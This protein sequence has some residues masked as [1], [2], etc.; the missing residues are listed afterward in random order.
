MIRHIRSKLA[1]GLAMLVCLPVTG[2]AQ[3]KHIRV[4]AASDLQVVMPQIAKAFEQQARIGVELTYGSSG[5]FFAQI[6]N[7][8]PFDLFFSADSEFPARL[9]RGGAAD[10]RSA[11]V[12][13]LGGL[14][15]WV[16]A[17]AKCNPQAERW[18]CLLKADVSKIAIANPAHAPY[19]RAAISAIQ[20]AGVYEQVRQKLVFGENISQA[21][22]F[23]QSGNAQAGVLAT[24]QTKSSGISEGKY[25]EVP[26]DS[27]PRIEQTVV[28]LKATKE[29]SAAE[30]FVK[31]VTEGP[32]HALLQQFGFQPP[33]T[34]AEAKA[35][36]K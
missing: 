4:A 30:E 29:K 7:G 10:G 19:G 17:K 3:Q 8:A 14:I 18:N 24:S 32:G 25:W 22:Q 9:V 11:A 5:N 34:S 12:Y 21:A 26:R 13:G 31:F 35:G 1:I 23:A 33:S 2:I 20:A 6:Q 16:P 28:V 36:R 15:L 27:Y